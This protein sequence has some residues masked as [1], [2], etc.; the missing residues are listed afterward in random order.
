MELIFSNCVEYNGPESGKRHSLFREKE[1]TMMGA[2]V[3]SC[4]QEALDQHFPPGCISDGELSDIASDQDSAYCLSYPRELRRR[5][6]ALNYTE[7]EST[8]DSGD[9]GRDEDDE[10]RSEERAEESKVYPSY[11]EEK[12]RSGDV[13][14]QEDVTSEGLQSNSTNQDHDSVEEENSRMERNESPG[15]AGLEEDGSVVVPSS[16]KKSKIV[17]P[18][19]KEDE[20]QSEK[21]YFTKEATVSGKKEKAREPSAKKKSPNRPRKTK[22]TSENESVSKPEHSLTTENRSKRKSE[23]MEEVSS[24]YVDNQTSNSHLTS[25]QR[26]EAITDRLGMSLD[27]SDRKDLIVRSDNSV[28]NKS[29]ESPEAKSASPPQPVTIAKVTAKVKEDL[30][31]SGGHCKSLNKEIKP[32]PVSSTR[33]SQPL[34]KIKSET[35][36]TFSPCSVSQGRP[37]KNTLPEVASPLVV[38]SN[39]STVYNA[40][41]PLDPT[42]TPSA[43]PSSDSYVSSVKVA[44]GHHHPMGATA[45]A[46]TYFSNVTSKSSPA[47]SPKVGEGDAPRLLTGF[48]PGK[49]SHFSAFHSVGKDRPRIEGSV[50]IK[51]SSFPGQLMQQSPSQIGNLSQH[52]A[53]GLSYSTF[54]P[55]GTPGFNPPQQATTSKLNDPS[56]PFQPSKTFP[57]QPTIVRPVSRYPAQA[58]QSLR[59]NQYLLHQSGAISNQA[60]ATMG[61]Q[62]NILQIASAPSLT[63]NIQPNGLLNSQ[64]VVNVAAGRQ[65]VPGMY[66]QGMNPVNNHM[67]QHNLQ[68]KPTLVVQ[69]QGTPGET[70]PTMLNF[71][72]ITS[73][74]SQ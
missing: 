63:L 17:L 25:L 12:R 32:V 65:T 43:K 60:P 8:S 21:L 22:V 26:L 14:V 36:A 13:E 72:Q 6:K 71:E 61:P 27:D 10:E 11:L 34:V 58:A 5:S 15:D 46:D 51:Q 19:K 7:M 38:P 49:S 31:L 53:K 1:Y 39:L 33:A 64:S 69:Y 62:L 48:R 52:G 18:T 67:V 4:F 35:A 50:D 9:T 37:S 24:N 45:T 40:V 66:G 59:Q 56:S 70:P 57:S 73:E 47:G 41:N 44:T 29:K 23:E 2:N 68:Q 16:P 55:S 74:E 54:V 3:A 20:E 30:T 42:S 28:L